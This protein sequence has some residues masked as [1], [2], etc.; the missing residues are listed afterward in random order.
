LDAHT[1]THE[2]VSFSSPPIEHS[3]LKSENYSLDVNDLERDCENLGSRPRLGD[4]QFERS[5]R[6]AINAVVKWFNPDMGFG[7]IIL[8]DGSGDAFFH[9]SLLARSGIDSVE[10]GEILKVRINI[11]RKGPHVTEVLGADGRL[12]FLAARTSRPWVEETGTV[13]WFK[14]EK[15]FGFVAPDRGGKDVFVDNAALERSDIP[16][17]AGGQRITVDVAEGRKGPRAVRIRLA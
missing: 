16:T 17:L 4:G 15:G 6:P 13:K 8:P 2:V 12:G 9:G 14:A 3:T 10:R 7:F 1:S 11:G 5:R